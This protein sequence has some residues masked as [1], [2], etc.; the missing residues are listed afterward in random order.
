MRAEASGP[1][2]LLDAGGTLL[3]QQLANDTQGRVIVDGMNLMGYDAM[4]LGL[5]DFA[6]GVDLVQARALEA[7]FPFLSANLLSIYGT[8]AFKPYVVIEK[9]GVRFGIIG[10]SDPTIG[11]LSTVRGTLVVTDAVTSVQQFVAEARPRSDVVIVLSSLGIE[12]DRNLARRVPGIDVILSGKTRWVMMEPEWVGDTAIAAA[13]YDGEWLGRLDA[14][15][16]AEGL[17]QAAVQIYDLVPEIADDPEMN[18]LLGAAR[19]AAYMPT[20]TAKP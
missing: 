1:V 6:Q 8:P 20:P 18:E 11:Q 2:L 9:E 4:G 17:E 15:A 16:T 5:Q 19:R 13:G 12:M 7:R 10:V 14:I 3:G